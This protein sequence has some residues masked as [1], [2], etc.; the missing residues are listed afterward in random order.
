MSYKGTTHIIQDPNVE[1]HLRLEIIP[2]K[3]YLSILILA[4]E[5]V[6]LNINEDH[7]KPIIHHVKRLNKIY[8]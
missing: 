3:A 6:N 8:P 2:Q 5:N 7:D 1:E 4:K